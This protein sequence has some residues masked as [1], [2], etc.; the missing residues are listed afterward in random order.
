[1]GHEGG[2][3]RLQLLESV[4]GALARQDRF[5]VGAEERFVEGAAGG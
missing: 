3:V 2:Y 5:H 1:V 4:F